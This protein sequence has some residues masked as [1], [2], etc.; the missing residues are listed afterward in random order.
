MSDIDDLIA[1]LE[2]NKS[3]ID[4]DVHE[5]VKNNAI[6]Y[7]A[8]AREQ[9]KLVMNK[10]YWTGNLAGQITADESGRLSFTVFSNAAYSGNRIPPILV[11][12]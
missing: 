3:M 4:D 7:A 5:I 2:R 8:D 10:G 11:I 12:A 6:E 1:R 9:A